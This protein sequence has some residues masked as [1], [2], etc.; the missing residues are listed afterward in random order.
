MSSL[1]VRNWTLLGRLYI[2]M[3][4]TQIKC[5]E[6]QKASFSSFQQIY[7]GHA[8]ALP[9]CIALVCFCD[10][11]YKTSELLRVILIVLPGTSTISSLCAWYQRAA[12]GCA[13]KKLVKENGLRWNNRPTHWLLLLTGKE[14]SSCQLQPIFPFSFVLCLCFLCY[15][16]TLPWFLF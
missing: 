6:R 8:K 14:D 4:A 12:S 5:H 10:S 11:P 13:A 9:C 3:P 7:F 15:I 1:L 2:R 16:S